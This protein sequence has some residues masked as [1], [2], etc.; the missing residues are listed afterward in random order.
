MT[1][2]RRRCSVTLAAI[3]SCAITCIFCKQRWQTPA[4]MDCAP[5]GGISLL[6]TGSVTFQNGLRKLVMP[7]SSP[8]LND[9]LSSR[10]P[11]ATGIRSHPHQSSTDLRLGDKLDRIGYCIFSAEP[12]CRSEEHTSELQSHS[13]LVCRLLLEKKKNNHFKKKNNTIRH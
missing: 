6:V 3:R 11:A 10:P 8:Q 1:S 12:A 2:H 4:F 9:R 13:D 5:N 7:S